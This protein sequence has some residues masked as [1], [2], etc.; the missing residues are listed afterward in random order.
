MVGP[1]LTLSPVAQ[2]ALVYFEELLTLLELGVIVPEDVSTRIDAKY[3]TLSL[4]RL[5]AFRQAWTIRH[6]TPPKG[7]IV[8]EALEEITR[9]RGVSED[10]AAAALR[11]ASIRHS[12]ELVKFFE[13]GLVEHLQGREPKN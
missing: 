6:P 8:G 12:P 9:G 10:A 11:E 3:G 4:E 7:E 5:E 1:T 2:A 13:D